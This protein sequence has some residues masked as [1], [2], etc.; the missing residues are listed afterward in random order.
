MFSPWWDSRSPFWPVACREPSSTMKASWFVPNWFIHVLG[1]K[2]SVSSAIGFIYFPFFI[3][4][5][6]NIFWLCFSS[7]NYSQSL[8]PPYPP[9]SSLSKKQVT[10]KLK[11]KI[12]TN[13]QQIRWQNK[14]TKRNIHK[15][16]SGS[17]PTKA[18]HWK[19][20]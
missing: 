9:N 15:T 6:Y 20:K 11:I 16:C 8:L 14:Q 5:L 19:R 3:I 1:L 2:S 4:Y 17:R 7:P 13:K 12:R 18:Q 10:K